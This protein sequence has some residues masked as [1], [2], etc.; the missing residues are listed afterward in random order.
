LRNL[1]S[2][3]RIRN[4]IHKIDKLLISAKGDEADRLEEIK[5]QSQAHLLTYERQYNLLERNNSTLSDSLSISAKQT[6]I[7]ATTI[8][9]ETALEKERKKQQDILRQQSETYKTIERTVVAMLA[10]YT[11]RAL[12]NFWNEAH[13]YATTYYDQ[14]NEIR[15]V[16]KATE[17][18]AAQMG[19]TYR[20]IAKDMKV[21]STDV[22]SA[23]VEF[24]RQG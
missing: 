16:T 11:T 7:Q 23:A 20:Q 24:W 12:T 18:E 5:A 1:N 14:L 15:I 10:V 8:A 22:A 21:S 6:Q 3:L 19:K 17:E 2:Q 13:T 4:Q 9:N